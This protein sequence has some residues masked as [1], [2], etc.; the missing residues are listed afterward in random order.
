MIKKRLVGVVTVKSGWA[1]QSFGYRRWLPLGKP[2]VLVENLDRWGADEILLQCVDRGVPGAGPDLAML[3]RVGRKGLSTPLIYA[4]GIRTAEQAVAA[5]KSGADRICVDALLHDAPHAIAD[6]SAPLGAQALIASL[7]MSFTAQG[8]MWLDYRS[9]RERP[10]DAEVIKVLASGAVSEALVI[11][12]RNEGQ[13]GGF[14]PRLLAQFPVSGMPL[15]AFGGLSDP[16]QL[17]EALELERV[18]AVAVGNFLNYREHA[19]HHYK[20]QLP[21]GP[22]R[23]GA[24]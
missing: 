10:L 21:G 20:A 7:P 18:A 22:L 16:R 12:W 2:E 4:G 19:I 23:P 14:D 1:V 8:L 9:G 17:R 6:L 5:V 15:I 24:L 13:P 11:D 3:E